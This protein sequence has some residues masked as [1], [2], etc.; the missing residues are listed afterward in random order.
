MRGLKFAYRSPE[1]RSTYGQLVLSL[2]ALTTVLDG[3]GMW[4]I[5][6]WIDPGSGSGW[7]AVILLWAA[8][9]AA[10]LIVLLIAP[11]FALFSINL[12]FP[13]LSERVFLAGMRAVDPARADG[14]AAKAG[15]SRLT[16]IR[17]SVV[18]MIVLGLLS[19]A[20]LLCSLIP[21]AGPLL[22]PVA[23]T[24]LAARS[25]AWELLDPYFDKRQMKFPE[26]HAFM[27]RHRGLMAGFGLPYSLML[28]I[29][30]FGPLIFGLA[31][32]SAALLV[33]ES[34]TED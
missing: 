29:P 30:L 10:A 22:A 21:V 14:L 5:W 26:Q 3:L 6:H 9:L 12:M 34:F 16:S 18:R 31:Q 23:Q 24:Y 2:L 32:A 11:V 25:V 17:V 15:L 27:Q 7:V 28:A 4:A 19:L 1:V 33:A 8:R 13:L 20:A